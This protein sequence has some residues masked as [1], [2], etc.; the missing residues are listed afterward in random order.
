MT[1]GKVP[2]L[3]LDWVKFASTKMSFSL[4]ILFSLGVVNPPK[5]LILCI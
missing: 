4:K 1:A 3:G 5:Q 2:P